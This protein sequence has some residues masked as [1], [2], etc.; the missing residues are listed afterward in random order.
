MQELKTR[1]LA[2]GRTARDTGSP[3]QQG[4]MIDKFLSDLEDLMTE[5]LIVTMPAE[6]VRVLYVTWSKALVIDDPS[7]ARKVVASHIWVSHIP[8]P[9]PQ[10]VEK[11]NVVSLFGRT[12][13]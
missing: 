10:P 9:L 6:A 3:E 2:I 5:E 1:L 8:R 11:G 4:L 7:A 12:T 13:H